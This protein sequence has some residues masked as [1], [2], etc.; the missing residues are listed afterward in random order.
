MSTSPVGVHLLDGMQNAPFVLEDEMER[1]FAS[2]VP[3][4]DAELVVGRKRSMF[5]TA[6]CDPAKVHLL[7][8]H[9]P[10][11]DV[12]KSFLIPN[13]FPQQFRHRALYVFN[14]H[15]GLIYTDNYYLAPR[16]GRARNL[17]EE[18]D[19]NVPFAEKAIT[20]AATYKLAPCKVGEVDRSLNA[21]RCGLALD[22]KSLGRIR[23]IGRGWP[24]ATSEEDS[25]FVDRSRSKLEFLKNS[26]FNL[27]YENC[28][29]DYYVS[30]KI[31]EAISAGCLPIYYANATIYQ[32]FPRN[33]FID[34]AEFASA[35]A[36]AAF[37]DAMPF[38]EYRR[39]INLCRRVFNY[40]VTENLRDQSRRRSNDRLNGFLK[41]VRSLRA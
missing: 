15:N 34:G 14:V 12:S 24:G 10:F 6:N 13:F 37:I 20:F 36:L 26:N 8:T 17:V 18:S 39:R 4:N 19:C 27:C 7:W 5:S 3:E 25:R 29:A 41:T 9:E 30:E 38:E 23:I 35:E 28:N 21:V 40:A 1:L 16:K 11:F 33:S 22:L 32:T 2:I 31:W